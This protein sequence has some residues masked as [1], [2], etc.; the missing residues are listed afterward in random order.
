MPTDVIKAWA[1]KR[2][3]VADAEAN[4]TIMLTCLIVCLAVL[5]LLFV[6]NSFAHAVQLMGELEF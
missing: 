2:K 3:T 1:F 5:I 4:T 6:S